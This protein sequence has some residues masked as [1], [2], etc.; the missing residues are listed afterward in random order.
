MNRKEGPLTRGEVLYML[1]VCV[2]GIVFS[3]YVLY[4][5]PPVKVEKWEPKITEPS[6]ITV[7]PL[8]SP[9]GCYS[10]DFWSRVE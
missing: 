2:L 1:V 9:N 3:L 6:V 5:A 8:D 7:T 10:Q 4:K